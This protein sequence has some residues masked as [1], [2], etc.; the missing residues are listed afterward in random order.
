[1]IFWFSCLVIAVFIDIVDILYV[2]LRMILN[3]FDLSKFLFF[4]LNSKVT[5]IIAKH[6]HT[7]TCN[8]TWYRK[9]CTSGCLSQ[10]CT[11][12]FGL[13]WRKVCIYLI[14]HGHMSHHNLLLITRGTT[15]GNWSQF[16]MDQ[17]LFYSGKS[18]VFEASSMIYLIVDNT[19]NSIFL[20][21]FYLK[22]L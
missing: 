21:L 12:I 13:N 17:C 7:T 8:I 1:M 2:K 14:R 22:F 11:P 20:Q 9:N 18:M 6:I 19:Y 5:A 10:W 16:S 15:S 3:I 4:F